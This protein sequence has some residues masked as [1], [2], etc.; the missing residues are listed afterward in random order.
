MWWNFSFLHYTSLIVYTAITCSHFCTSVTLPSLRIQSRRRKRDPWPQMAFSLSWH[1]LQSRRTQQH[2]F[3][4]LTVKPS[5]MSTLLVYNNSNILHKSQQA[6]TRL[7]LCLGNSMKSRFLCQ[8]RPETIAQPQDHNNKKDSLRTTI[9]IT[10]TTRPNE[11]VTNIV[12]SSLSWGWASLTQSWANVY[13]R[14]SG[15]EVY[16]T[17]NQCNH[18]QW[19]WG[20]GMM[21]VWCTETKGFAGRQHMHCKASSGNLGKGKR[22]WL[23]WE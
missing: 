4:S 15:N 13:F 18:I 10:Q 17:G 9:P 16:R 22:F 14:S 8:E 11:A 6:H 12:L 1:V 20:W 23:H 21:A 19:W 2:I 7:F 5:F 3:I